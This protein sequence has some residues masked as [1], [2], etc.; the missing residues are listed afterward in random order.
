MSEGISDKDQKKDGQKKDQEKSR[1]QSPR[2]RSLF[3]I[4]KTHR[5]GLTGTFIY[6]LFH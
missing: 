2:E 4:K 5:K 1:V 6:L 3:Y